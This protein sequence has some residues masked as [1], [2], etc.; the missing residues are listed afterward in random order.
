[1]HGFMTTVFPLTPREETPGLT[2][3]ADC[4][5]PP[6]PT[7][8]DEHAGHEISDATGQETLGMSSAPNYSTEPAQLGSFSTPPVPCSSGDFLARNPRV[9]SGVGRSGDGE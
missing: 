8:E 5:N 6:H 4:L 9:E 3:K 2:P 1:M 7:Y